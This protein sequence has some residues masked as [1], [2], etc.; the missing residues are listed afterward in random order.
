MNCVTWHFLH[1]FLVV[2][3]GILY[4]CA[5]LIPLSP[6]MSLF[7]SLFLVEL[8]FPSSFHLSAVVYVF[9]AMGRLPKSNTLNESCVP[10]ISSA[11]KA[12]ALTHRH[13]HRQVYTQTHT[14]ALLCTKRCQFLVFH[15]VSSP[16]V[17]EQTAA[18]SRS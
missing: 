15:D 12:P 18:V 10:L 8:F 3:P 16:D 2:D 14:Q 5:S 9:G 6:T 7:L 1:V 11:G 17:F 4:A 13:T